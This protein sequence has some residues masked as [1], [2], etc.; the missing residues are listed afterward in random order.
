M[1]VVIGDRLPRAF[2]HAIPASRLRKLADDAAPPAPKTGLTAAQE[3]AI[4]ALLKHLMNPHDLISGPTLQQDGSATCE[5]RSTKDGR[6]MVNVSPSGAVT[7][8]RPTS[9]PDSDD[10]DTGV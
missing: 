9:D 6:H 2:V 7:R 3:R 8:I 4:N 1:A 10:A 5:V